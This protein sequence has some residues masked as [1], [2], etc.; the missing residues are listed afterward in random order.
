[1]I[2]AFSSRIGHVLGASALGVAVLA[3]WHAASL[4]ESEVLERNAFIQREIAKRKLEVAEIAGLGEAKALYAVHA[5]AADAVRERKVVAAA[6]A[7]AELSRLPPQVVMQ[8]VTIESGRLSAIGE[9]ASE[10]D[11]GQVVPSLEQSRHV[12]KVRIAESASAQGRQRYRLEAEIVRASPA[13]SPGT[14][15]RP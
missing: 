6:E 3:A 13:P 7:L 11:V 1:M 15:K 12:A 8:S 5:R 9:A 14:G 4:R 2:A 10:A